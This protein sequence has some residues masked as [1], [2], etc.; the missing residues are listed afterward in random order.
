MPGAGRT[1]RTANPFM[2]IGVGRGSYAL[3][4]TGQFVDYGTLEGFEASF[5]ATDGYFRGFLGVGVDFAVTAGLSVTMQGRRDYA[6]PTPGD[7]FRGFD[8]LDLSG[9]TLTVGL[10]WR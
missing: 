7:D 4:Q 5:A 1:A 9:S 8:R 6:S 2:T 3:R 10:R